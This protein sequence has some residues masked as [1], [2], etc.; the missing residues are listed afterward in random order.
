MALGPPRAVAGRRD[1]L[2]WAMVAAAVV[3]AAARLWGLGEPAGMIFDEVYYVPAARQVLAGQEVTEER[4]HPPLSKLII[5]ASIRLAGDRPAGWRLASAVAGVLLVAVVYAFARAVDADPFVAAAS[6]LLTAL[7]GLVFVES[8]IAKPDVFLALFVVTAYWA[9]WRYLQAGVRKVGREGMVPGDTDA[10]VA[11]ASA[12]PRGAGACARAP[13]AGGRVWLYAAG[14]AAG[15]AMATKWT[16]V[17]PLLGLA[18]LVALV[19]GRAVL[20]AVRAD[21]WALVVALGLVPAGIYLLTYVPYLRVGHTLGD[22]LAV[23]RWMLAFHVGLTQGHP[24][25]SAWWS[26]PLLL[27]PIW[28]DYREV[29]PEL[30]RGVLAIGNPV[31]WWAGLPAL[32]AAAVAA[33]RRSVP[34]AAVL[35]GFA[36]AWGQYAF[37]PRV[38]FLYHFLLAVPFLVVAVAR[39]LRRVRAAAGDGPVLVYL[40]LAA[41]WLAA[42]VP[43]LTGQP[44][45]VPHFRRLMWF[46]TWI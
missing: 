13:R 42:F 24:Y 36:C 19:R 45:T 22:V 7:D 35:V 33:A 18:V 34:D 12:T 31:V 29:A 2:V 11:A 5:A 23:Q 41:G 39:G 38:L 37:I 6:A 40:A 32:L 3:A 9:F 26:W 10:A 43:L 1:L 27:R 30:A 15:C 44:I 16:A 8:R 17:P 25:Q 21:A 14:I 28:Y 20:A 4:T 46:G